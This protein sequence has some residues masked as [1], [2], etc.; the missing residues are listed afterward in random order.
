M[1]DK[2]KQL[3]ERDWTRTLR[4]DNKQQLAAAAHHQESILDNEWELAHAENFAKDGDL[5]GILRTLSTL[6]PT[7]KVLN[8]DMLKLLV[9]AS[10]KYEEI[11]GVDSAQHAAFRFMISR[12]NQET[13]NDITEGSTQILNDNTWMFI[14]TI[15]NILHILPRDRKRKTDGKPA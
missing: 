15:E 7:P 12:M 3:R 5:I 2:E 8:P 6:I 1:I 4:S 11:T 13:S 10:E 9:S 14:P